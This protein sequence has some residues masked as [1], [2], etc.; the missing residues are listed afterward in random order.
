MRNIIAITG[1]SGAGKTT[2]GNLLV[3]RNG[4]VVPRHCTTR[5]SRADDSPMFYRYLTHEEYAKRFDNGEFLISSGDGDII[6]KEFGNYYGILKSDCKS[7]FEK[8][9]NII[10]YVSYKDLDRLINL[11]QD[12]YDVKLVNLTFRNLEENVKKRLLTDKKRNHSAADILK[13]INCALDYENKYRDAIKNFAT[14]IVFTDESDIEQTYAIV[15]ADL[16]IGN[17]LKEKN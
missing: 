3:E 8:S 15:C 17:I 7:A 4:F 13:R 2:L 5:D 6:K 12:G 14:S 9:N 11:S 1:P 16:N 10:L